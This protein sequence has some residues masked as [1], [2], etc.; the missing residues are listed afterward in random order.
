MT[1]SGLDGVVEAVGGVDP[2]AFAALTG[3]GV[4]GVVAALPYQLDGL[5]DGTDPSIPLVV[6][7]AVVVNGLLVALAVLVGLVLGADAGFAVVEGGALAVEPLALGAVTG[8]AGGAVLVA[9][10][11]C[12]FAPRLTDT[13]LDSS[14][15][16]GPSPLFGLLASLYGGVTE[17]L[18]T[19]FGLVSLLAWIGWRL[20]GGAS[21]GPGP[22]VVWAAV[23]LAAA[24]FGLAHLPA[25]ARKATLTP[26]VVARALA[27]NGLPG[28]LFGW[29][30][31]RSGLVVAM[32]SHFAADL[33]VH[34]AFPTLRAARGGTPAS[35]GSDD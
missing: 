20:G 4:V 19:R 14:V 7:N 23:P 21:G 24:L 31:W 18:L 12:L 33:V 32:V 28:V 6:L 25:T 34:V 3:A 27:L 22:V 29:L 26:P 10:D 13:G 16:G 9:L 30:F 17:E 15:D 35:S 5:D 2:A 1:G 8:A 11:R